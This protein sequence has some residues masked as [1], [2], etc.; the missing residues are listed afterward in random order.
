MLLLM[1]SIR[2]VCMVQICNKVITLHLIQ[3]LKLI[4]Q[5]YRPCKQ[6]FLHHDSQLEFTRLLCLT[7][8]TLF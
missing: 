8:L 7:R 1:K 6:H 2:L 5:L 3:T 4:S